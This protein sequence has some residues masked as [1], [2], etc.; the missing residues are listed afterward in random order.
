MG[1]DRREELFHHE[2]RKAVKEVAQKG[3]AVSVLGGFCD[4]VGDQTKPEA[5]QSG[6][7]TVPL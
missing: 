3:C 6:L 2:D 1:L 5:M 4:D 7:I